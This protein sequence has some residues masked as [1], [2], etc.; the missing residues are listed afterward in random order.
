MYFPHLRLRRLRKNENLRRMIR[1]TS[2]SVDDLIYPLFVVSGKNIKE[3]VISM[4]GVYRYSVDMIA[5]EAK[6][7]YDLGIP[8]V[9]L[10]G[11]PEKKDMA[12]SGAY[13]ENGIVQQAL[14]GLKAKVENLVLLTD[15]CLCEYMS[16]GHC[17]IT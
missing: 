4:P 2:I 7:V 1:E 9:I 16:H 17:G 8:A 12:A 3:E 10:F 5:E 14:R 15:V 6:Q 11:I 13:D